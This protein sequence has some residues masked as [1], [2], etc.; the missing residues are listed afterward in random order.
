VY[1]VLKFLHVF[2]SILAIGFTSSFGLIQ[3]RA[4]KAGDVSQMKFALH[5]IAAMSAVSTGCFFALVAIGAVMVV[6]SGIGFHPFW[7]HGSL[8]LWLVAFALGMFV[9]KPAVAKRIELL[10]SRGPADPEFVA[11]GKR[12]AMLGGVLGLIGLAIVWLMVT[13]PGG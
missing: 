5:L 13:K 10:E 12:S 2:L 1:F 9:M 4:R 6:I 3:A 8:G 7:V 11:L